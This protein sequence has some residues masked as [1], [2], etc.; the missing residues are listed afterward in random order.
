MSE[1]SREDVDE[2]IDH[3]VAVRSGEELDE[4]R[5]HSYLEDILGHPVAPLELLQFPAGHS[6]LTYLVRSGDEEWVLRRPPLGARVKTGHDM[7]REHRILSGLATH[8]ARVPRP[9][10]LCE[11][12]AILGAPFY[13]MERIKGLIVRPAAVEGLGWGEAQWRRKSTQLVDTLVEIHSLDYQKAGLGELGHPRGYVARQVTGWTERYAK[14]RTDSIPEMDEVAQWLDS[15]QPSESA[16]ALIHNDFKYDN[17]VFDPT[18]TGE[19]IAVLDWEMATIGDPLMDL[20]TSLAYWLEARDSPIL[21]RFGLNSTHEPGNLTRQEV[22]EAYGQKSGRD[23]SDILFYYVF[24]LFKVAVIGQQIYFRYHQGLTKDA[25]FAPLIVAV[26]ALAERAWEAVEKGD[27][28][29]S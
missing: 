25:R 20:G 3:P 5:L 29:P 23:V 14:S 26:R 11:D 24:G 13:L 17:V 27:I 21:L 15:H 22:V 19:V 28:S 16:A 1:G 9:V 7:H 18:D 4:Q 2:G 12:P 8:Y 10:A 6:N